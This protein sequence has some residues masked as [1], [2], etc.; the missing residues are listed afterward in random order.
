MFNSSLVEILRTLSSSEISD[1]NNY[2][3]SPY[4]NRNKNV[5]GLFSCLKKYHPSYT[6]KNLVKENVYE[7][8]FNSGKYNKGLMATT[9]F[10][11][12]GHLEDW[13][14]YKNFS[15]NPF[16]RSE[17]LLKEF[18][19][20]NLPKY[21][22][23][24]YLKIN[25]DI[26][27]RRLDSEIINFKLWLNAFY[28]NYI[29]SKTMSWENGLDVI[30]KELGELQLINFLMWARNIIQNF[31]SRERFYIMKTEFNILKSLFESI[32][33][34][35]FLKQVKHNPADSSLLIEFIIYQILCI[36]DVDNEIYYEQC[37]RLMYKARHLLGENELYTAYSNLLY[38][39]HIKESFNH[40]KYSAEYWGLIKS[41]TETGAY[42]GYGPNISVTAFDAILNT[43]LNNKEISWTEK[44]VIKLIKELPP[45]SRD[46]MMYYTYARIA[47]EKGN[48]DDALRF[49]N[50]INID[51]FLLKIRLRT[52]LI[53]LYYDT[54]Q[55]DTVLSH[56]DTFRHFLANKENISE[57]GRVLYMAF[58]KILNM[59]VSYRLKRKHYIIQKIRTSLDGTENVI[60]KLWL[61]EKLEELMI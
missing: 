16:R 36:L 38:S 30:Y 6:N 47:A 7:K 58:L 57:S 29:S 35:R 5:I 23:K 24:Q 11:L 50:K 49:Y 8:V 22:E 28:T 45:V 32:N 1:F 17:A 54:G 31:K 27:G 26:K 55:Y 25:R 56:I 60:N 46:N 4:F 12:S 41:M 43:A 39:A 9:I 33:I 14:A 51:S 13:M 48:F 42:K 20:R 52:F 37:R 61:Y 3:R 10:H 18:E 15:K 59:F 34:N 44:N 21:Y 40:K 2:I 19:N 53:K